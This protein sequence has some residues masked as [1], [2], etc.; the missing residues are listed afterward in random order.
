[1]QI[2]QTL[3]PYFLAVSRTDIGQG[4]TVRPYTRK[5]ACIGFGADDCH[6]TFQFCHTIS[7][8]IRRWPLRTGFLGV[9][10]GVTCRFLPMH[11]NL[12]S[13]LFALSVQLLSWLSLSVLTDLFRG[14]PV[15]QFAPRNER[16]HIPYRRSFSG[17]EHR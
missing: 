10:V 2:S 8:E 6:P 13:Q 15:R 1:M 5:Q 3:R 14:R 7:A 17:S 11:F 12:T 9:R 4:G 16:D